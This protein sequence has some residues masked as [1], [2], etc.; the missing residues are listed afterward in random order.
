MCICP[1]K[2][3]SIISE[4]GELIMIYT[5]H[6]ASP[7][8]D[9]LLASKESK[10]IGL[11]IDGQKHYMGDLKEPME[12]KD[13]EEI[14]LKTKYWLDRYFAGARPCI[15]EL[16]MAPIGSEFRQEVWKILKNIPYGKV[17]TYNDIAKEMAQK[18]GMERMSPQAIGGAVGHNPISIIVPCHRVVGTSGSLTG[19]AGGMDKKVYLLRHE[20][21]DVSR[22]FF[23]NKENKKLDKQ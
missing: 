6:Y 14:L 5:S 4:E 18:R 9:I 22:L 11:W 7:L 15:D 23:P 12:E 17:I 2:Y 8:G 1:K 16:E 20:N 13:N 10:L 21:V 3:R 19:Y